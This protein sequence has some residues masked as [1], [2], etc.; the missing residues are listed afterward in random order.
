MLEMDSIPQ[1][2]AESKYGLLLLVGPQI[3]VTSS[4]SFLNV[5]QVDPCFIGQFSG[6][7][8][9]RHNKRGQES[10]MNLQSHVAT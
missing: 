8:S 2:A 7:V 6:F 10:L 1:T 5:T 4:S 9:L 3:T